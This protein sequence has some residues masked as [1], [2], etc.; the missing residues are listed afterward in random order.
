M[1]F[2][3]NFKKSYKI[4]FFIGSGGSTPPPPPLGG[5]KTKNILSIWVRREDFYPYIVYRLRINSRRAAAAK[6]LALQKKK[7]CQK[8]L[9]PRC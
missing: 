6:F 1:K 8:L 9:I 2:L 4:F 3:P 5:L 7:F